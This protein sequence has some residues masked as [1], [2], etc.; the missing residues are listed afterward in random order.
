MTGN[1]PLVE[2]QEAT[3]RNP[4]LGGRRYFG[5]TTGATKRIPVLG[6]RQQQST[7]RA[8][9]VCVRGS[10]LQCTRDRKREGGERETDRQRDIKKQLK[11][12]LA[13]IGDIKFVVG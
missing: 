13:C 7:M 6:G 4:L 1:V 11:L 9:Q 5:G 3:Q 8:H 12:A 10:S 2:L